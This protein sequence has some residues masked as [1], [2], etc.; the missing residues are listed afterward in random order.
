[1]EIR[2]DHVSASESGDY[3][4]VLFEAE[5]DG[6]GAYVLVQR[7]F[8]DPDGGLCYVEA[9]DEDYIG[10]SRVARASLA[11]NR[12]CLALQRR[13]AAQ[14]NVTFETTEQNYRNVARVMRIMIPCL[15]EVDTQDAC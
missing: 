15:E 2:L 4:Q 12:F 11:R 7:Q 8:E 10:H 1:M 6:D 13:Q 14:V 9:H 5:K 3:F